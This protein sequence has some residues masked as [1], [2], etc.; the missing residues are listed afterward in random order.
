LNYTSQDL[1]DNFKSVDQMNRV[2]TGTY[3][4][5]WSGI[6]YWCRCTEWVY[7]GKGRW[8][9]RALAVTWRL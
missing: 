6:P 7:I 4:D 2:F 5:I 9:R 1:V 3:R 8:Y